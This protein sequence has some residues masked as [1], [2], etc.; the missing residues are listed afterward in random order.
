ME[1]KNNPVEKIDEEKLSRGQVVDSY[2]GG[3][4]FC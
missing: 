2:R 4:L 1:G 3:K